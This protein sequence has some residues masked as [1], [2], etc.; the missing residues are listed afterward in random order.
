M[1]SLPNVILK[2][3][4]KIWIFFPSEI[5]LRHLYYNVY[6]LLYSLAKQ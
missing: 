2:D 5:H 3:K 4:T 1:Q 6:F